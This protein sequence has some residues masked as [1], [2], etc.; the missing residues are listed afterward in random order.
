MRPKILGKE[1]DPDRTTGQLVLAAG[2][3]CTYGETAIT[4]SSVAAV[5]KVT[6]D[7]DL[8][9]TA[10]VVRAIER[11]RARVSPSEQL[12]VERRI[13]AARFGEASRATAGAFASRSGARRRALDPG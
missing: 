12:A 3:R 6:Q 1:L 13:V 7:R 9:L 10:L 2:V 8:A 4:A 11:A 5:A